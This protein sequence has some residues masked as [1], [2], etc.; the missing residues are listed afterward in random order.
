MKIVHSVYSSWTGD[1]LAAL[2]AQIIQALAKYNELN[3]SYMAS[4]ALGSGHARWAKKNKLPAVNQ[5]KSVLDTL[6]AQKNTMLSEM[7]KIQAIDIVDTTVNEATTD[8]EAKT[9]WTTIGLAVGALVVI[10]II[11]KVI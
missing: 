4:V 5:A 1:D 6:N 9:P 2:D 3:N 8:N 10:V 11:V 7:G